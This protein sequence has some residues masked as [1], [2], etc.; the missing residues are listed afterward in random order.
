[1]DGAAQWETFFIRLKQTLKVWGH[2]GPLRQDNTLGSPEK[3]WGERKHEGRLRQYFP[4]LVSPREVVNAPCLAGFK[5]GQSSEQGNVPCPWQEGWNKMIFKVFCNP[6]HFII[7]WFWISGQTLSASRVLSMQVS[8][9]LY[10]VKS[11]SSSAL[12]GYFSPS[13]HGICFPIFNGF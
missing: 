11:I 2:N 6:G 12:K 1:M 9:I 10:K 13:S 4:S 8:L 5:V 3:A 7:L